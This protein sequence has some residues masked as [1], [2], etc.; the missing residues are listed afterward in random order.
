MSLPYANER[1]GQGRA[2][3]GQSKPEAF[4]FQFVKDLQLI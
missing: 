3:D 2:P 4:H 1:A